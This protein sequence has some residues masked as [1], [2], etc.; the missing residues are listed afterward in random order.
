MRWVGLAV[1]VA[2]ATLCAVA[3]PAQAGMF[4]GVCHMPEGCP[5]VGFLGCIPAGVSVIPPDYDI[6]ENCLPIHPDSSTPPEGQEPSEPD[7]GPTAPSAP[8]EESP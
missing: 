4:N 2:L 1:G 8:N 5:L 7:D 6:N 3:L